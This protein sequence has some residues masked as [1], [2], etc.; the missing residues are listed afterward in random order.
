MQGSGGG[1]LR[2]LRELNRGLVVDALRRRGAASRAELARATGLS[3][4]TI[5]TLAGEL[6]KDGLVVERE[7]E[8][9]PDGTRAGRPPVLLA[10]D[11]RA[12]T[13]L[14]IDFGHRHIRVAV[15]DLSSRVLAEHHEEFDVDGSAGKALD[16]AAQMAGEVLGEAGVPADGVF[17]CGVGIPSPID[18]RTG[19]VGSSGIL[20]G[21]TGL[22]AAAELADRLGFEVDV[23]NDATLGALGEAT[24]GA[25]RGHNDVIYVKLATGIGAGLLL[26]GRL[27]RGASGIAGELGH[28]LYDPNGRL[29]RCGSRGCLETAAAAPAIAALLQEVHGGELTT[30][31]VVRLASEGDVGTER[32]IRDAGRAVGRVLADIVNVLNPEQIVLGGEL[33]GAGAPLRDGVAESLE[34]Y[35][36]PAAAAAVEV[37]TGVLGE[38]A[39]V[40]GALAL[41]THGHGAR[42]PA[43]SALHAAPAQVLPTSPIIR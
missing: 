2:S 16:R 29:C 40:L 33:A 13:V 15:A 20:P 30:T 22:P 9:D 6:M 12:G 39:E 7:V 18:Q 21:W 14:G 23:D 1:A 42:P 5:S 3:R 26:G 34:R 10:L 36:L 37:Q 28:V 41:V 11:P 17:G 8:P 4:A 24:Q 32:L 27:H 31:D 38:R 43:S 19:I 25:A 35:A